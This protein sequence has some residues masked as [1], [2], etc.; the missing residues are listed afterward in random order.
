MILVSI[1]I[2]A[3]GVFETGG[4]DKVYNINKDNDRLGFFTFSG[5]LTTRADTV[6]AWLGQLF[7]SM[8]LLGCQQNFVQRYVSMNTF[9]EV[10]KWKIL[11]FFKK[12]VFIN[13][14]SFIFRTMLTNIPVI[15]I[16]FSLSWVV[17]MS[18]YST[19]FDCD[20]LADNY[21]KKMDEILPFFVEDKFMYLPGFL[22]LF[23]ATLFNGALR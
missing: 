12:V 17:G 11:I 8:S 20:P 9:K 21:I 13:L 22:G 23:M 1:A 5:D 16:L 2:F 19:Y 14:S 18:I 10:K 7:I 15:F 3:Q 6:S 4:L